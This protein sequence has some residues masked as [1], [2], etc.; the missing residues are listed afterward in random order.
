M[1]SALSDIIGK[2]GIRGLYAG[3][4]PTL[5][6]IVP[7]AGLQ[8]GTYD[9]FK[10][11]T[12][13]IFSLWHPSPPKAQST[14]MLSLG[15]V[16]FSGRRIWGLLVSYFVGT[17]NI[18]WF[19]FDLVSCSS[20][21][22]IGTDLIMLWKLMILSQASS[23]SYVDWLLELVLKLYVIHLMWWRR[24][25]KYISGFHCQL[26]ILFIHSRFLPILIIGILFSVFVIVTWAVKWD[27]YTSK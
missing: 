8:F 6:E 5:V 26:F 7:Y 1:R 11:W 22:G 13:V 3:L 27:Y 10:R 20:R 15:L 4:T 17:L 9:T 16:Q 23:F 24:D 21:L 12:M 14:H 19:K 25:F 18:L 2:R